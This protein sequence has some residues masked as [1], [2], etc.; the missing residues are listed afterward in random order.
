[1]SQPLSVLHV[2]TLDHSPFSLCDIVK[3]VGRCQYTHASTCT[4]YTH[5]NTQTRTHTCTHIYKTHIVTHIHMQTLNC[6]NTSHTKA[7]IH[8][9]HTHIHPTRTAEHIYSEPLLSQLIHHHESSSPV[10]Q[11]RSLIFLVCSLISS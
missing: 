8:T 9:Q 3:L 2:Y 11:Y 4:R 5:K 10:L 6:T 1:M 7:C